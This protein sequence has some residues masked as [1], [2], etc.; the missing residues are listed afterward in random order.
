MSLGAEATTNKH[1]YSRGEELAN[2]ITHGFGLAASIAITPVLIVTAVRADDAWRVVAASIFGA[3]L[4]LLYGSSTLYH[5]VPVAARRAK[6]V[7]RRIDHSMIYLLIA[8]TYTPFVLV[9]LRG[10][11][12]WSLFGIVWGLAVL[13]VILK[14]IFGAHRLPAISTTVYVGMGWLAIIAIRP[15]VQHLGLTALLWLLAGG[16]FYTGGVAFYAW[17][18]RYSHAIWHLFVLGGSAAHAWAILAYV[19]PRSN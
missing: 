8:G 9:S 14:G 1:E 16:L 3:V 12:G 17:R 13:G 4:V 10:P 15:M 5:A 11:W 18:K 7:C 2:S 19:I 6:E